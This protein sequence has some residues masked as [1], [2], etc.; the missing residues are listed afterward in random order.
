MARKN[1]RLLLWAAATDRTFALVES[2]PSYL[3][4]KC[5]HCRRKLSLSLRGEPLGHATLEHILPRHH[6][7]DDSLMNIAVACSK[8]N[9]LKGSRIDGL[10]NQHPTYQRVIAQLRLERDKRHRAPLGKLALP[11]F[12]GP[13]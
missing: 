1:H 7:G 4:G 12:D 11:P 6:G 5:L 13:D 2:S 8:C 10:P 9:A 3:L